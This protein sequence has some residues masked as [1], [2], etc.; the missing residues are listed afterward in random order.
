MCVSLDVSF[1]CVVEPGGSKIQKV[2]GTPPTARIKNLETIPFV[3]TEVPIGPLLDRLTSEF[4]L[5]LFYQGGTEGMCTLP[6]GPMVVGRCFLS[7]PCNL[8]LETSK[9]AAFDFF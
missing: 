5:T 1:E 7:K 4:C 2:K 8:E 6:R 9:L 3:A